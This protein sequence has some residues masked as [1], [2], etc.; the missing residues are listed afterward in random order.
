[1][2]VAHKMS[3]LFTEFMPLWPEHSSTAMAADWRLRQHDMLHVYDSALRGDRFGQTA[4]SRRDTCNVSRLCGCDGDVTVR[5]T[6]QISCHSRTTCTEM[7][8]HLQRNKPQHVYCNNYPSANGIMIIFQI[9][10][11]LFCHT[12]ALAFHHLCDIIHILS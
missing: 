4:G 7:V 12:T 9:H 8:S 11:H 10:R 2:F 3:W 1:L 5:R 6:E